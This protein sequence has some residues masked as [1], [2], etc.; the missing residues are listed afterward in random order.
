MFAFFD[1][2]GYPKT[3]FLHD[4]RSIYTSFKEGLKKIIL[5]GKWGYVDINYNIIINCKYEIAND[6]IEG[7]G[8]AFVFVDGKYGLIDV[9]GNKVTAFIYDNIFDLDSSS[10][11]L[12]DNGLMAVCINKKWGFI[13]KHG[14]QVVDCIYDNIPDS[15]KFYF[16]DRGRAIVVLNKKWG[17]ID[18]NGKYVIPCDYD[19]II[20]KHPFSINDS[21][22]AVCKNGKW[23]FFNLIGEKIIDFYFDDI[24]CFSECLTSVMIDDKWGYININGEYSIHSIF[25][26]AENFKNG[27]AI[28]SIDNKYGIINKAGVIIIQLIYSKI[29]YSNIGNLVYCFV[30]NKA[31]I[32]TIEGKQLT[33][34]KYN[35]IDE[36]S[37]DIAV[38]CKNNMYGAINIFG[39]EVIP[40]ILEDSFNYNFGLAYVYTLNDKEYYQGRYIDKYGTQYWDK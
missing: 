26:S 2:L 3:D 23:G 6:F 34:F 16:F 8:V 31:A 1:N 20:L 27:I 38:V 14:K 32:F 21:I 29:E 13:N 17:I 11:S 4:E 7:L 37:N 22:A 19:Y 35:S 25:D 36:I 28:V 24:K 39:K 33:T 9:K 15:D 12:I 18:F 40:C 30:E 10:M 5:N